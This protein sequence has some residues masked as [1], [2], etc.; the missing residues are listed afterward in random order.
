MLPAQSFEDLRRRSHG[1]SMGLALEILRNQRTQHTG[2]LGSHV[3]YSFTAAPST[4]RELILQPGQGFYVPA[5]QRDFTWGKDEISR[6]FED[7]DHGITRAAS[8]QMPR[9]SSVL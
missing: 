4:L 6:L 1:E 7:F 3:P 8:G 9:H 2:R 5:Y